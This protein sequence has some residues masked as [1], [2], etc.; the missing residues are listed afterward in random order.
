LPIFASG[1]VE[2]TATTG[3]T[4]TQDIVIGFDIFLDNV[5]NPV[6]GGA[7]G[8]ANLGEHHKTF[9][10]NALVV[11]GTPP[12]QHTLILK[13]STTTTITSNDFFNVTILELPF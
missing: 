11:L 3:G 12:Q 4:A 1:S 7:R 13:T 10:T 6:L 8:C 9:T 5:S 2:P